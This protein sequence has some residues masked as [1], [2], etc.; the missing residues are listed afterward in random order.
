MTETDKHD[1]MALKNYLRQQE[2]QVE[3]LHIILR[4]NVFIYHFKRWSSML[5]EALLYVSIVS[6]YTLLLNLHT[7]MRVSQGFNS[8]TAEWAEKI[9]YSVLLFHVVFFMVSIPLLLIALTLRSNRK[10]NQV[11]HE[12]FELMTRLRMDYG[13]DKKQF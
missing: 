1:L 2:L 7:V 9:Q 6:V 12:A 10:K 13:I 8:S 11:I 3:K 4:S 5:L